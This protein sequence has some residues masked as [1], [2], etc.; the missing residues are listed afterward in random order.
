MKKAKTYK[1]E[2]FAAI[3]E[4]AVGMYDAGVIDKQTMR[5]FDHTCLTPIHEF[6]AEQIRAL[7][8]REE[9]S[10]SVFAR[11]LNVTKDY[12]SK[13]ERGEK[14]LAGPSLKLL[15]LIEKHGLAAI[16]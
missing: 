1:S 10:Q 16:A 14:K 8:E 15:S 13:W 6:T 4:T 9:V 5:S 12:V 7:R 2:A 3:H 11:Y